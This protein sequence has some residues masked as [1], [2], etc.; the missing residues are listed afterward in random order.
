MGN[1]R[2]NYDNNDNSIIR[3]LYCDY[4]ENMYKVFIS[5]LKEGYSTF[6]I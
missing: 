6:D 4:N 3:R 2:V 1:R 5:V